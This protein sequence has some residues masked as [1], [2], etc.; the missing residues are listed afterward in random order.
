MSKRHSIPLNESSQP[1]MPS[2]LP[3]V[4]IDYDGLVNYAKQ[5]GVRVIELSDNEKN[6]FVSREGKNNN[7]NNT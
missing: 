5:K 2:E 3:D 6:R 7:E 4:R 1:I